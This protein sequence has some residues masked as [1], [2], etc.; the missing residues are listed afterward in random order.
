MYG[1][2]L[3][4]SAL[5]LTVAMARSRGEVAWDGLSAGNVHSRNSV[6]SSGA[7]AGFKLRGCVPPQNAK[8]AD[9]HVMLRMTK[10]PGLCSNYNTVYNSREI[11]GPVYTNISSQKVPSYSLSP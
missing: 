2:T 11:E 10:S 1:Q 5:E 9:V 4:A 8:A 6:N 7:L 3:G